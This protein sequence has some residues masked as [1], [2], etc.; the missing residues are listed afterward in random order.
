[1]NLTKAL[2]AL[3]K[4]YGATSIFE[5]K[6]NITVQ[7]EAIPS[8]CLAFDYTL[9]VGGL[10]VGRIIEIS[11]VEG[12]GKTAFCASVIAEWQSRGKRCAFI[13]AEH[14][15]NESWF[16]SLGVQFEQ[17]IFARPENLEDALDMIDI[18]ASSG[19]VDLIVWDS[20]PALPSRKE[21]EGQAGDFQ[22]ASIAKVLSPGLRKLTPVFNTKKCTGIFINQMREKISTGGPAHGNPETTPGG[23]ALKHYCSLRLKASKVFGSEIKQG[24]KVLGHRVKLKSL[25]NKLSSAQG[26]EAEFVL[27]Y[28]TGV[29]KVQDAIETALICGTV[30]RPNN[31]MYEFGD[32]KVKGK[33]NF[34][35][36]LKEDP[37]LMQ[38][39]V[40]AVRADMTPKNTVADEKSLPGADLDGD[41]A[42]FKVDF[43]E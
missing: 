4:K 23:R 3:K 1:V 29:D 22:V 28:K 8:G 38:T 14:A 34:L 10:P 11:G 25:K 2:D 42:E 40:S 39:L 43:D 24:D 30:N 21:T 13:D 7:C 9:G 20:V 31:V 17:L 26:A 41:D 32:L 6:E 15:A 12:S 27:M 5:G 18:L 35:A 33:D 37:K 19:E 36:A 16:K